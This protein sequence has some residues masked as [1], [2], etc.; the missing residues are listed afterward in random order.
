MGGKEETTKKVVS[1][2]LL[3]LLV[4]LAV[5]VNQPRSS[6]KTFTFSHRSRVSICGLAVLGLSVAWCF[7]NDPLYGIPLMPRHPLEAVIAIGGVIFNI[8]RYRWR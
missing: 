4:G 6:F 8:Y 5:T 3:F 2:L 7:S 1:N